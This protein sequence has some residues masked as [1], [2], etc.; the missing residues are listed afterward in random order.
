MANNEENKTIINKLAEKI[1]VSA[2][3]DDNNEEAT[4]PT[5]EVVVERT[6]EDALKN[7][8][9]EKEKEAAQAAAQ[10]EKTK[11]DTNT[12][13]EPLSLSVDSP[14]PFIHLDEISYISIKRLEEVINSMFR[15]CFVDFQESLIFINGVNYN[16]PEYNNA[17]NVPNFPINP[18]N[19]NQIIVDLK[20]G[21][22]TDQQ[23]SNN[24][25]RGDEHK[26]IALSR[27]GHLAEKNK[28][29]SQMMQLIN[30]I[31]C[32]NRANNKTADVVLTGTAKRYLEQFLYRGTGPKAD[33]KTYSIVHEGMGLANGY[34]GFGSPVNTIVCDVCLDLNSLISAIYSGTPDSDIFKS[35]TKRWKYRTS[36]HSMSPNGIILQVQRRDRQIESQY[37][38]LFLPSYAFS[39]FGTKF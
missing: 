10:E 26:V 3:T 33:W 23:I 27:S 31:N 30:K 5:T 19:P 25:N 11:T 37:N 28:E 13:D 20:F 6:L 2:G 1:G 12:K 21:Y 34:Y 35:E 38:D 8:S 18:N 36:F 4:T 7:A 32:M 24:I 22:M 15:A 29:V 9:E 17:P 39:S 16:K 14:D